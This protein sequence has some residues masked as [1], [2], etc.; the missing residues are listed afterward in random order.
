[1]MFMKLP[2]AIDRILELSETIFRDR[3]W[4]QSRR[5]RPQTG[6]NVPPE[7]SPAPLEEELR[8]VLVSLTPGVLYLVLTV[9]EM[10]ESHFQQRNFLSLYTYWSDLFP[11]PGE[12]VE[13]LMQHPA[14]FGSMLEANLFLL[15]EAGVDVYC[16]LEP[17]VS[18]S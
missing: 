3:F 4:G 6:D 2:K 13:R 5:P 7:I 16:L 15:H 17:C 18:R 14:H 1:M 9:K 11:D 10:R 12:V 8:A